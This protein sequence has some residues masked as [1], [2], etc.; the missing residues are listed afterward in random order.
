MIAVRSDCA[1]QDAQ[2]INSY[3]YVRNNPLRLIDPNGLDA[4]D[5]E[6]VEP[7]DLYAPGDWGENPGDTLATDGVLNDA[8]GLPGGLQQSAQTLA[9]QIPDEV[10]IAIMDSVNATNTPSGDD[11]RGGFHEE[12][13]IAGPDSDNKMVVS[14]A[15]PG[16]HGPSG[17]VHTNLMSVDPALN[18]KMTGVSVIWHT[19]PAGR[20]GAG[21][22][23]WK[24]TPSKGDQDAA[25]A[26]RGSAPNVI[27]VVIGTGN[28]TVYFIDGSKTVLH[29]CL[30]QFMGT[31][32]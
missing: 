20:N 3:A 6:D 24:Q 10:K 8:T 23:V 4:I 28:R 29:M 12:G 32:R 15:R 7:L 1:P 31:R 14:P 21:D 5:L 13:G 19:H 25:R 17:A 2:G 9:A 26:D 16:P 18:A 27:E 22:L 11:K 30:D